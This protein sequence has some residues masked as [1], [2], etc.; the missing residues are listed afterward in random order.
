MQPSWRLH[1]QSQDELDQGVLS[2]QIITCTRALQAR[3]AAYEH[4]AHLQ[5]VHDVSEGGGHMG[6]FIQQA[7]QSLERGKGLKGM[8]WMFGPLKPASSNAKVPKRE[9]DLAEQDVSVL[10]GALPRASRGRPATQ[11]TQLA[12]TGKKERHLC[13]AAYLRTAVEMQIGLKHKRGTRWNLF[14]AA[15][16]A[17]GCSRVGVSVDADSGRELGKPQ[18]T[19]RLQHTPELLL[20]WWWMTAS[21]GTCQDNH[22]QAV[23]VL[24]ASIGNQPPH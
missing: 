2:P 18:L 11:H 15:A 4:Q 19:A 1:S 20:C 21:L 8:P 17:Q 23:I 24:L 13:A 14:S 22:N 12:S 3:A 9:I 7:Q 5:D 10:V 16:A 6:F